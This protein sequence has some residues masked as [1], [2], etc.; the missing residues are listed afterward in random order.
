MEW[1][2]SFWGKAKPIDQNTEQSWHPLVYHCLDV[3][4]V[5]SVVLEQDTFRRK[6]LAHQLGFRD[7]REATNLIL[8]I[9]MMHDL[10]KFMPQFQACVPELF[11]KLQGHHRNDFKALSHHHDA[12]GRTI[13]EE[14]IAEPWRTEIETTSPEI[15]PFELE[16]F[17]EAIAVVTTGHHG[18]PCSSVD[19][20]FND[21]E[22]LPENIRQSIFTFWDEAKAL[23]NPTFQ[24]WHKPASKTWSYL[25]NGFITFCDWLGSNQTYFPYTKPTQ[26]FDAYWFEAQDKARK[27]YRDTGLK[28]AKPT[29]KTGFEHLV[30]CQWTPSDLQ[31]KVSK[32]ALSE[33]PQLFIVEDLTGSGKTE[34]ALIL[35][36]RL[37][38][39]GYATGF[40]FGLPT[41]ATA[42]QMYDRV[43][44]TFDKLFEPAD[45]LISLVLA[46]GQSILNDQFT[47]SL[48][49]ETA[50]EDQ[51]FYPGD[52]G[53]KPT[54][55]AECTAWLANHSKRA[56]LASVGVGTVDQAMSAALKNKHFSMRLYGLASKVL[57]V[58]E[59]HCYDAYMTVIIKRLILLHTEYGG[60]TLLLSATMPSQ[61]RQQLVSAYQQGLKRGY[62]RN[63]AHQEPS[64]NDEKQRPYPCLWHF[65]ANATL[66][67][68]HPLKT[69]EDKQRKV[70]VHILEQHPKTLI[71]ELFQQGRCI[72]WIRNTV[73]DAI[74]AYQ[75][76]VAELGE[77]KV[78]LFHARFTMKDRRDIQNR[79]LNMFGKRESEGFER[80]PHV[81]IATQVIEQSL[82]VDFDVVISDLAPMD[83]LLQR[84]GRQQRHLRDAQG[85]LIQTGKDARG[86]LIFRIYAPAF[87]ENPDPDWYKAFSEAANYVYQDTS[88]LWLTQKKLREMPTF[89]LPEAVRDL[90]ESAYDAEAVPAGLEENSDLN[91]TKKS[92]SRSLAELVTVSSDDDYLESEVCQKDDRIATRMDNDSKTLR[93][94]TRNADGL[95]LLHHDETHAHLLSQASVRSFKLL[96]QNHSDQDRKQLK[97]R[98]PDKN[99]GVV[100]IILEQADQPKTYKA[101]LEE[102]IAVQYCSK[103]GLTIEDPEKRKSSC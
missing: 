102:S 83:L 78:T 16:V 18:T 57:I 55:T 44:G 59:A 50:P 27:A 56:L 91:F 34:A 42:D 73:K 89:T 86:D 58:D 68:F 39:E 22:Y 33:L 64:Y 61:V 10:G 45:H 24:S 65:S 81:V 75:E 95:Q 88:L 49:M 51:G 41:M 46:Q 82:D 84:L 76:L 20:C 2:S 8:L 21:P 87:D 32:I 72:T 100:P 31:A 54:A 1:I 19:L 90:I 13:F 96:R 30:N 25:L 28:P 7:E 26:S 14:F 62:R 43:A 11:H 63:L 48:Q 74:D 40:Y 69:A 97:E 94:F 47:Q 80:K 6:Q 12:L 35:A 85:N 3:A 15:D 101:T 99:R 53:P 17:I 93:F 79:V 52:K 5:A 37:M 9:T 66:P 71:A 77:D 29:A 38:H 70:E 23:H 36:H 4:A 67:A 98:V 60:H 103:H 92:A